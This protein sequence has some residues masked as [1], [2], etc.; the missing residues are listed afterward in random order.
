VVLVAGLSCPGCLDLVAWDLGVGRHE[1]YEDLAVTV[2]DDETGAETCDARVTVRNRDGD[3]QVLDGCYHA[4]L[5]AGRYKLR[6]Y[7]PGR[8][9]AATW[10]DV[11]D[12]SDCKPSTSTVVLTIPR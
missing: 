2:I 11:P 12:M 3:L 4:S 5:S 8:D 7:L 1:C 9:Y 10:L 6:A